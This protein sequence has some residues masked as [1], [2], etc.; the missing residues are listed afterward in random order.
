MTRNRKRGT[1]RIEAPASH[2]ETG[3]D[4]RRRHRRILAG[5]LVLAAALRL[6]YWVE[7]RDDPL[8]FMTSRVPAFDPYNFVSL[9]EDILSHHGLGSRLIAQSPVY[10]YGIAGVFALA[11]HSVYAVFAVQMLLGLLAVFV[12]DRTATLLFGDRRYGL[13]AALIGAVYSPLIFY[14]GTILRAVPIA[15]VNLV[16][17]YLYLRACR[18]GRGGMFF[19]S[20]LMIG[21]ATVLRPTILPLA[22]LYV[23]ARRSRPWPVR[24]RAFGLLILGMLVCVAP[25]TLRN[26]VLGGRHVVI[27]TSSPD[28]FWTGNA[29]HYRGFGGNISPER[30]ALAEETKEAGIGGILRVWWREVRRQPGAYLRVY[31]RKFR[32]LF[33]GYEVPANFSYDLARENSR[34]LRAAFL[35]FSWV[36][37]LGLVGFFLMRR[38]PHA[39]LFGVYVVLLTGFVFLFHIQSRY[40][41]PFI[42]FVILAAAYTTV[43][44]GTAVV[45]RRGRTVAT[46]LAAVLVAAGFTRPAEGL[47]RR[48]YG[49]RV[50]SIDYANLASAYLYVLQKDPESSPERRERFLR[51]S[52]IFYRKALTVSSF[53]ESPRYLDNMGRIYMDLGDYPRA[54]EAFRQVLRYIPDH[55]GARRF[56]EILTRGRPHPLT[57]GDDLSPVGRDQ[58]L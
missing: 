17:F 4:L 36:A 47:V 46:I 33:N 15:Y 3:T 25:L 11:G 9:A 24:L 21:L 35:G 45:E 40:R 13:A 50:R 27:S 14:E 18:S 34:A 53:V 49:G 6:W 28:T 43:R 42:P 29:P 48:Y 10:A 31:G 32:M 8:P 38:H 58:R 44:L 39:G 22:S 54:L 56:I 26:R 16:G 2:R 51:R 19:L 57:S 1:R 55:P 37:P 5:I 7:L 12:L 30:Q 41:I 23:L 20:G 52:L